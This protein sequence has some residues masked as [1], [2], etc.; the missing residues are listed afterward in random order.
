MKMEEEFDVTGL[1]P[2]TIARLRKFWQ[3]LQ[4]ARE[5]RS[6]LQRILAQRQA[7]HAATLKQLEATYDSDPTELAAAMNLRDAQA[8]I[9]SKIERELDVLKKEISHADNVFSFQTTAVNNKR[10]EIAHCTQQIEHLEARRAQLE[11]ELAE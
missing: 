11:T 5:R 4:D 6:H 3:P 9:I 2:T 7:E 8:E 10:R 1:G